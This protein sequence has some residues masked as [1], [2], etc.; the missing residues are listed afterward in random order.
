MNSV[1]LFLACVIVLLIIW[2]A[3]SLRGVNIKEYFS[4][5]TGK[6]ILKGVILACA[7]T[8]MMGA[9]SLVTGC[10]GGSYMNDVSVYAGLDYTKNESPMCAPV[11]ADSHTTSNL[12]LRANLYESED[13]KFRANSKYTHHSCAFSPDQNSYDALGVEFDYKIWSN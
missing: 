13:K 7:F 1:I 12:G 8:A 10:A 3:W 6:G 2:G 4:G 11:G 5:R 9:L